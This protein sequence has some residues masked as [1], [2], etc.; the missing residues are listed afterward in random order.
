MTTIKT[1]KTP[2]RR[3]IVF[4][5]PEEKEQRLQE[6]RNII[7]KDI[8]N[9]IIS[10][11]N[12]NP[13]FQALK[14]IIH[15]PYPYY[16]QVGYYHMVAIPQ[17]K[18]EIAT[19]FEAVGDTIQTPYKP[20]IGSFNVTDYKYGTSTAP[21]ESY[22]TYN[23]YKIIQ[24]KMLKV[25]DHFQALKTSSKNVFYTKD[26]A[27]VKNRD[28]DIEYIGCVGHFFE[29]LV[30]EMYHRL[31]PDFKLEKANRPKAKR[32]PVYS[33]NGEF[34]SGYEETESGDCL[35]NFKITAKGVAQKKAVINFFK[36][37]GRF[38]DWIKNEALP[39]YRTIPTPLRRMALCY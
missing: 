28:S 23:H 5:T 24:E 26:V 15:G 22:Y 12:Y 4:R 35:L 18:A 21:D 1:S 19:Y 2:R 37:M 6:L 10:F 7:P 3:P 31:T 27:R 25:I 13:T 9:L 32:E 20:R 16:K 8:V 11:V 29:E 17:W 33:E 38:I 14:D 34:I 36:A 30:R 39:I